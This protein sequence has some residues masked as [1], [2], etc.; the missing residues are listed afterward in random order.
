MGGE[1]QTAI[2]AARAGLGHRATQT[3]VVH[4]NMAARPSHSPPSC[5]SGYYFRP[6]HQV[7]P[8]VSCAQAAIVGPNPGPGLRGLV[9]TVR[10]IQATLV[11][12]ARTMGVGS[13]GI[14]TP[15][16]VARARRDQ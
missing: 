1:E 16:L 5:T 12:Q 9:S 13:S 14:S 11:A 10:C 6:A 7:D 2:Y 4:A 15:T 3:R 8:R